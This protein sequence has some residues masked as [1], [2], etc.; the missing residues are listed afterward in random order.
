[1]IDS[2]KLSTE[3]NLWLKGLSNEHDRFTIANIGKEIDKR[4]KE[5]RLQAYF[6]TIMQANPEAMKEAI[7]MGNKI[8][9][10]IEETGLAAKWEAR[11]VARGMEKAACNALAQGA[12]PEFVQKI[13]GLPAET[14][15][16]LTTNTR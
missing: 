1:V 16:Q 11:G 7:K 10:I 15:K 3:E 14:I 6:Y 5:A 8:D 4:G 13:T 2:R 9:E 12:S